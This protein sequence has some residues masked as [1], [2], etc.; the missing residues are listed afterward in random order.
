MKLIIV[1]LGG[2]GSHLLLP[3]MQYINYEQ[4]V[5]AEVWFIDGDTYEE[6]NFKRQHVAKNKE[7]KALAQ[8]DY[9]KEIFPKLTI[10]YVDKYVNEDN[11][12]RIVKDG[13]VVLLCVDNNKTRKLFEDYTDKLKNITI[14]SGGNELYDG[15]IMI[16]QKKDEQMLTRKFS[17]LHPELKNPTDKSPDEMS[18]EELEESAPQIGLVNATVA[19]LMRRTLYAMISGRGINYDEIFV[20]C[21][22]G[23]EKANTIPEIINR[24]Q[25][26]NEITIHGED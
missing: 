2:I 8:M 23:M 20:N 17:E 15:N 10:S 25:I 21:N 14:I 1:G 6:K 18:C 12:S 19:D 5:F 7:N 11:I 26:Q 9:Y 16:M 4:K 3:L 22:T 13:D 24:L